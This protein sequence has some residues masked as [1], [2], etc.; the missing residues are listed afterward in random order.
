MLE[1][2]SKTNRYKKCFDA[3]YVKR[4]HNDPI[5]FPSLSQ[6]RDP[7]RF[8]EYIDV[9]YETAKRLAKDSDLIYRLDK[10]YVSYYVRVY[11]PRLKRSENDIWREENFMKFSKLF[12]GMNR[13]SQILKGLSRSPN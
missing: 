6:I 13:N 2:L 11:A 8:D 9:Y 5:N 1:A 3:V 4:K 7:N 12:S 10:K